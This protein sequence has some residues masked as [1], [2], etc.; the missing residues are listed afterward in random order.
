MGH[1]HVAVVV[2]LQDRIAIN[3]RGWMAGGIKWKEIL[4]FDLQSIRFEI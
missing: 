3:P 4:L 1:L 2:H